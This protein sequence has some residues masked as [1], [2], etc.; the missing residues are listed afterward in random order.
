VTRLVEQQK[1]LDQETIEAEDDLIELQAKLSAAVSRLARI[2]RLRDGVKSRSEELFNRGMDELESEAA[3][4]SALESH[5]RHVVEDLHALGVPDN[6][7]FSVFGL[8]DEFNDITQL[9][10]SDACTGG[11][12]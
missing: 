1:K 9:S 3:T 8:G 4:V 12:S 10:S 5:E 7:D 2:R 11:T 6:V